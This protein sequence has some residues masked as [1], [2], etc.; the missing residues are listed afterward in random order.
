VPVLGVVPGPRGLDLSG[1]GRGAEP[2]RG[3]DLVGDLA[4]DALLVGRVVVDGAAVL[5]ATV[6]ALAVGRGG[7][8]RLVQEL[9]E[10]AVGDLFRVKG[11]LQGLGICL[12]RRG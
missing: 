1:D 3:G 8:V 11:D 6:V 2:L 10:L 12:G 7:V 5:G 9:D 4:G